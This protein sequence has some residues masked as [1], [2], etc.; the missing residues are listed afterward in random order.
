M[1]SKVCVYHIEAA[2]CHVLESE[3]IKVAPCLNLLDAAYEIGKGGVSLFAG[4]FSELDEE[5]AVAIVQ[6]LREQSVVPIMLLADIGSCPQLLKAGAD[7]CFPPETDN[8]VLVSHAVALIRRCKFYNI[9]LRDEAVLVYGGLR[10]DPLRH[11]GWLDKEEIIL[12]RREFKLLAYFAQNP[13]IVLAP[14]KI[15]KL[16]GSLR[17]ITS[18]MCPA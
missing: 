4:D 16:F 18:V 10:L 1:M 13:G 9:D 15:V 7:L 5:E 6:R 17:V 12:K 8:V 11:R 14:E 2:L 3:I